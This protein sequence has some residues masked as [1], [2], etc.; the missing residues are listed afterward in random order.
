VISAMHTDAN[1]CKTQFYNHKPALS[2]LTP[3]V[4]LPTVH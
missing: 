2:S 4:S 1:V 3:A